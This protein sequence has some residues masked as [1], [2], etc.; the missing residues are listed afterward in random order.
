MKV[1]I[2]EEVMITFNSFFADTG[3]AG[4]A[5]IKVIVLS[6]HSLLILISVSDKWLQSE[7]AFNSFFADT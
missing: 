5:G 6:I 7:D 4:D 2:P 1:T 3:S